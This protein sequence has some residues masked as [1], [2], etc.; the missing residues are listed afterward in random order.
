MDGERKGAGR[1]FVLVTKSL[2]GGH[3]VP[4]KSDE[5]RTFVRE[6]RPHGVSRELLPSPR[7][8][9]LARLLL[10]VADSIAGNDRDQEFIELY[11]ECKTLGEA[12]VR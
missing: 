11:N 1:T 7:E 6:Q 4:D 8:V 10:R 5:K 3:A 12:G 9:L 2:K